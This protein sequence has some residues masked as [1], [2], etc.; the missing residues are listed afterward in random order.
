MTY[1]P[2]SPVMSQGQATAPQIQAWFTDRGPDYVAYAPDGRY[3]PPPWDLGV[4][5]VSE[6]HRYAPRIVNHDLVAAQILHETAAWQSRYARERNNPGGIGAIN[7]DPDQALTFS[8][9]AEGIRAHV[10][11][12][13]VYCVGD[14]AWTVDDRRYDAVKRAGWVGVVRELEDFEGRW[15]WPGKTYAD[16]IAT[17]ANQLLET[18]TPMASDQPGY[19]WLAS[20]NFGYPRGTRGRNGATVDLLVIHTTEAPWSSAWPWLHNPTAESSTHYMIDDDGVQRGQMVR[21]ADAAW[22]T[23]NSAYNRRSIN[24]EHVGYAD[25]GGFSDAML[26]ES[27]RL[28][29]GIIQRNPAI[30]IDR[31]HIIGHSEV[32]D[33]NDPGR[34]GGV[35]NHHDPGPHWPWDEYLEMIREAIGGGS[36]PNT[37]PRAFATG[38][39]IQGSIRH[40]WERAE[41]A[42]CAYQF[43]G[44][45]VSDEFEATKQL[46]GGATRQVVQQ[47]FERAILEYDSTFEFPWDVT[48]LPRSRQP[49]DAPEMLARLEAIRAIVNAPV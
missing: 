37:E 33:P 32:P 42:D 8:T 10:A 6:C 38:H 39:S 36:V 2:Q 43:I 7:S 13:L 16:S 15:A 44:M 3:K 34:F 48:A 41:A 31:D 40:A 23:G 46:A 5:I 21:E 18:E 19:Q 22:T 49:T 20:P 28:A 29:V 14:G 12:V 47:T 24:I 4:A 25:R 11:H 30:L 35:G 1:T 17:L 26:R 27:A 45:P 9:V